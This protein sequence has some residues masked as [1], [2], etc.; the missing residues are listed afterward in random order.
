M[1]KANV[2]IK[3][4]DGG[5]G[6]RI[7]AS[8]INAARLSLGQRVLLSVLNGRLAL[9]PVS[10]P[11]ETLAERLARFDPIRHGGE[12]MTVSNRIPLEV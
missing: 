9:F 10:R 6:I 8:I 12:A 5:L 3:R 1:K 11:D 4:W 2:R 7:P